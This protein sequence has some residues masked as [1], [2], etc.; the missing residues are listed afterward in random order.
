MTYL[1]S[2]PNGASAAVPVLLCLPQAGASA[3]QFRDWQV[4]LGSS[5]AVYA[6]Q[7][8]GR[9]DRWDE[10]APSSIAEVV[11]AVVAELADAG[12]L[13]RPLVVF[14]DSF[15]GLIAYELARAVGP[16]ALVVCVSRAPAHWARQGG[17]HD[18]DV[19]RLASASVEGSTLPS[20]LVAE[21]RDIAAEVLR[22]DAELSKTFRDAPGTEP[23]RCPVYAW[24]AVDDET[25]TPAQL[26]DWREV[27]TGPLH[28]HD[29]VGGHRIS[30]DDPVT[31]LGRLSHVLAGIAEEE[32]S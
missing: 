20:A 27:T 3:L 14:G 15:G 8:P 21:L 4:R 28:R 13:D 26:D 19:E 16:S 18:N 5:A 1:R 7:L 29:F 32:P 17:L 11:G 25:V 9:E 2:W 12:L 6:V 30:R 23:L 22:R 31:V 24:G 10:P